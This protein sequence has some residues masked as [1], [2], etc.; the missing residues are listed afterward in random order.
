MELRVAC[1]SS[2]WRCFIFEC[3][4]FHIKRRYTETHCF[5]SSFC[6]HFAGGGRYFLFASFFYFLFAGFLYFL[7]AGFFYFLFVSFFF[8]IQH[9][10]FW[11]CIA[12]DS[13][14]QKIF[15]SGF[16]MLMI[17]R[18]SPV[19]RNKINKVWSTVLSRC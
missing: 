14:W 17:G 18:S 13:P 5:V 3:Q 15:F 11:E 4:G 12:T 16:M 6:S 1:S 9:E 19:V 10:P 7:Y 8:F 2:R